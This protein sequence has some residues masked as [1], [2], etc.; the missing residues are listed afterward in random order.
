ME[1]Y[2]RPYAR[3]ARDKDQNKLYQET[4]ISIFWRGMQQFPTDLGVRVSLM[5]YLL[6]DKG[7]FQLLTSVA[8]KVK[9]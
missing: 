6:E 8:E 5:Q 7:N 3:G 2:A 4:V 9:R 1:L